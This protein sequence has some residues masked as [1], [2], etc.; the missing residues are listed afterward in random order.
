MKKFGLIL[1]AILLLTFGAAQDKTS[2]RGDF[3]HERKRP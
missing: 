2:L 1:L 3:T